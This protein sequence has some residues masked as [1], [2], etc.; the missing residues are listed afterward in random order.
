MHH[1]CHSLMVSSPA[2]A[3]KESSCVEV[4]EFFV[5]V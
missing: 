4:D 2:I 5:Y 3:G 1:L